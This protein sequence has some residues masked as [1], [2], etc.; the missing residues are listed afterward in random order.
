MPK[1]PIKRGSKL[2]QSVRTPTFRMRVERDLKKY[3]RKI[4][5][6]SKIND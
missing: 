1:G 6:K 4:K 5:H 3:N 2:L